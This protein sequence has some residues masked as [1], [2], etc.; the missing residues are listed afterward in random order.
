MP[1]LRAYLCVIIGH[2]SQ[3]GL[4]PGSSDAENGS[5]HLTKISPKFSIQ[6]ICL[7]EENCKKQRYNLKETTESALEWDLG[8]FMVRKHEQKSNIH[9][10]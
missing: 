8:P 2:Q 3:H 10:T 4:L 6:L 1:D 9:V 7:N 5:I